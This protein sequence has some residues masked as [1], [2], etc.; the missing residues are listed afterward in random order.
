M[1]AIY[2]WKNDFLLSEWKKKQS[3]KYFIVKIITKFSWMVKKTAS[4][5]K[6]ISL[7]FTFQQTLNKKILSSGFFP[8]LQVVFHINFKT[9]HVKKIYLKVEKNLRK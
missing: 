4:L 8:E 1:T 5:S 2:K 7:I 3:Y 9:R 6:S